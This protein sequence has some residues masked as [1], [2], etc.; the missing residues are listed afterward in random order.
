MSACSAYNTVQLAVLAVGTT[1]R[2]MNAAKKFI[3][4]LR[5]K[6]LLDKLAILCPASR[7]RWQQ[8]L[9]HSQPQMRICPSRLGMKT[10]NDQR[11]RWWPL[12]CTHRQSHHR[13]AGCN[14]IA[15]HAPLTAVSRALTLLCRSS[16]GSSRA[17]R[18]RTASEEARCRSTA[19]VVLATRTS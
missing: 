19:S 15:V 5:L 16:S 2:A 10:R 3:T 18:R 14:A 9:V 4:D 1:G 6:L 7:S 8:A 13:R 12:D 17:G 11:P